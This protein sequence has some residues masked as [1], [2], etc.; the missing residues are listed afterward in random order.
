MSKNYFGGLYDFSDVLFL[1]EEPPLRRVYDVTAKNAQT[2]IEAIKYRLLWWQDTPNYERKKL[3]RHLVRY[4]E[5]LER[6]TTYEPS[7]SEMIRYS[8][9]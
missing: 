6:H 7:F 2:I 9:K 8:Y 1:K 3:E 4:E 5:I